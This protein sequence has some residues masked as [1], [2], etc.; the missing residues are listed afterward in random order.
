M[1]LVINYL[2]HIPSQVCASAQSSLPAVCC[3]AQF[4]WTWLPCDCFTAG[5]RRHCFCLSS[6]TGARASSLSAHL[7]I[8]QLSCMSACFHPTH[9][10][11]VLANVDVG[12]NLCCVDHTVLLDEDVVSDVQREE[13]HSGGRDGGRW[14]S[15]VVRWR[16]AASKNWG[17]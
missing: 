12:T 5:K 16:H 9:Y 8:Y 4:I 15:G 1:Q 2:F 6:L 3:G 10:D 13:R 11:T 14:G 7:S 17:H